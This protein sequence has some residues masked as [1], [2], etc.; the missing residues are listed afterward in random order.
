M[1]NLD[2]IVR[3]VVE[4]GRIIHRGRW[5]GQSDEGSGVI[6]SSM[7]TSQVT[8]LASPRCRAVSASG[9]QLARALARSYDRFEG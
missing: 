8:D 3:Q 7:K 2:L 9:P 1:T 4:L 6:D 5:P